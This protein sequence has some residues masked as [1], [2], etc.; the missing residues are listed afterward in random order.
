MD[1]RLR[2]RES[3]RVQQRENGG[4]GDREKKESV[5]TNRSADTMQSSV[6][7]SKAR[8]KRQIIINCSF[9]AYI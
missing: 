4:V 5:M 1:D 8:E 9:Y 7:V 3:R 2:E 6:C